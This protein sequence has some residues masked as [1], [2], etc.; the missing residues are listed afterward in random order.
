MHLLAHVSQNCE[1]SFE[2]VQSAP[3]A[4][5]KPGRDTAW[6]QPIIRSYCGFSCMFGVFPAAWI[7]LKSFFSHALCFASFPLS[8]ITICILLLFLLLLLYTMSFFLI[9]YLS[10]P[11]CTTSLFHTRPHDTCVIH[12]P[13][14][15]VIQTLNTLTGTQLS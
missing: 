11:A 10:E 12:K 4:E 6:G 2:C 9:L 13:K 14:L 7:F 5:S 15:S 3:T 1:H 8:C